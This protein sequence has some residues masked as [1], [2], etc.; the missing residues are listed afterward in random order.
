MTKWL[1]YC[2]PC[3]KMA[4]MLQF[5]LQS[6]GN[7]TSFR[8][9]RGL[10]AVLFFCRTKTVENHIPRELPSGFIVSKIRELLT[11]MRS[12]HSIA[13]HQHSNGFK[14]FF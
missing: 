7:W 3:H 12:Y 6:C 4:V 11:D 5:T 14:Q 2:I 8:N 10:A 9:H 1:S 13:L